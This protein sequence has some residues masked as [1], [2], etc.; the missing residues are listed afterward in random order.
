MVL[1]DD[2]LFAEI[3]AGHLNITITTLG[4]CFNARDWSRLQ[5]FSERWL[6]LDMN[7][8]NEP[9]KVS[10]TRMLLVWLA[11]Y[12]YKLAQ[13]LIEV[14][15]LHFRRKEDKEIDTTLALGQEL[16]SFPLTSRKYICELLLGDKHHG[17]T[18]SVL[19][20]EA[21]VYLKKLPAN[22]RLR[23]LISRRFPEKF[24]SLED[25]YDRMI[26][27]IVLLICACVAVPIWIKLELP[28][29]PLGLIFIPII[30]FCFR[31]LWNKS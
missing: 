26:V 3:S 23:S 22:S 24:G 9:E 30:A 21:F 1:T 20:R 11:P 29:P 14:L 31:K 4:G 17:G 15:P 25:R 16:A 28:T 12:D 10:F 8:L 27:A 5:I 2:D 19:Q 18:S 6:L 13:R 7:E